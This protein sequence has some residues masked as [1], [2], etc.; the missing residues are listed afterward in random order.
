MARRTASG[1]L[2]LIALIAELRKLSEKPT[3]DRQPSLSAVLQLNPALSVVARE[4]RTQITIRPGA[5]RKR[6]PSHGG[7][8]V[9]DNA[10]PMTDRGFSDALRRVQ[11]LLA[12][13]GV[14]VQEVRSG[15]RNLMRFT[16][17]PEALHAE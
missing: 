10:I 17:A 3:H 6:L 5:L 7:G 13:I 14:D 9:R 16:F 4:D 12:G 11:P 1:D 2:F 15:S 8:Y